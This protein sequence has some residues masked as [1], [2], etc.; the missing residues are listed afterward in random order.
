M[1]ANGG[2]TK[3]VSG[4]VHPNLFRDEEGGDENAPEERTL[5]AKHSFLAAEV[6]P[7]EDALRPYVLESKQFA[8]LD[9]KEEALLSRKIEDGKF[10]SRLEQHWMTRHGGPPSAAD[11]LSALGKNLGKLHEIFEALCQYV[12]FAGTASVRERLQN[13]ALRHAIDGQIQPELVSAMSQVTGL[14]SSK[15]RH[16][17]VNLSV[18]SRLIP[19][20]LVG[21][22]GDKNTIAEFGRVLTAPQSRYWLHEQNPDLSQHFERIRKS[23]QESADQLVQANLRLVIATARKKMGKGMPLLDLIQE[24]NIGLIRAVEKFDH[25]KGYKFSTYAVWW[26]RQA[27]S[28]AI[29][30]QSRTV[31]LPAHMVESL[32]RLQKARER[33]SQEYGRLP[34]REELAEELNVPSEKL[35]K[36]VRAGSREPISLEMPV[37]EEGETRIA[38]LIADEGIPS[39]EERVTQDLLREQ[40]REVLGS[41]PKRQRDVIEL[42]FGLSNGR[43]WT[44]DEVGTAMGLTRERIRQIEQAALSGLRHS[45][46]SC[47]LKDYLE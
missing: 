24:G 20:D 47:E 37:G 36:L 10:L 30:D 5:E 28:R 19:W 22:A 4:D 16:H 1:L 25:R 2:E 7:E 31:R 3:A 46:R 6:G 27:I 44:L 21:Q 11:L 23:S 26:I 15:V 35:E 29:A 12:G 8:L 32:T 41:L 40:L 45:S 17:L 42:R 43:S 18:S 39:P 34:T 33:L 13:P 14:S 9:A 38:D